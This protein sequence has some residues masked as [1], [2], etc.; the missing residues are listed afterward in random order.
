MV[1][2]KTPDNEPDRPDRSGQGEAESAATAPDAVERRLS[3]NILISIAIF[4]TLALLFGTTRFAI[5]VSLGGA[6]AYLNYRWLHS[7]LKAILVTAAAG[8]A[9]PRGVQSISKF[10]L[11]WLVIL[12]VLGLAAWKG[13]SQ[14]VIGVTVG[15][16]AFAGAAMMEA[17]AQAYWGLRGK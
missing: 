3:R 1:R 15:L 11:R 16:F 5:G 2:F 9:P 13:G 4:I 17:A 12:A 7:S 6:L 8:A 10:L 14:L